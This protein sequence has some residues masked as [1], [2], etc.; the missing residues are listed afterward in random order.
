MTFMKKS[1][2]GV[3]PKCVFKQTQHQTTI[4]ERAYPSE[5][6]RSNIELLKKNEV[7]QADIEKM[8]RMFSAHLNGLENFPLHAISIVSNRELSRSSASYLLTQFLSCDLPYS[9][10]PT[11]AV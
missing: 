1:L 7:P 11:S 2:A 9:L 8:E 3:Y 4:T 10:L 6:P 5:N